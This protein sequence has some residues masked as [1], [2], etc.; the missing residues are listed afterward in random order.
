MKP[1]RRTATAKTKTPRINWRKLWEE[2]DGWCRDEGMPDWQDQQSE[3]E[4]L[5]KEQLKEGAR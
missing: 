2:F 1:S 4:R 3:I 5:V